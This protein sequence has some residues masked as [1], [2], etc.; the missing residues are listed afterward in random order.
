MEPDWGLV[1]PSSCC[2]SKPRSNS[3]LQS[4]LSYELSE[5]A[6][7][8]PSPGGGA[9]TEGLEGGGAA[10]GGAPKADG[11]RLPTEL[12]AVEG[13]KEKLEERVDG[14]GCPRKG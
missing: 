9:E 4:N 8:A 12:D 14:G 11:V 13:D 1:G 5:G 10:A 2:A 6:D 7:C 3:S